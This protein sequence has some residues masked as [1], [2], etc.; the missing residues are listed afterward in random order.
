MRWSAVPNSSEEADWLERHGRFGSKA[1][2]L[3]N[4]K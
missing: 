2:M 3:D 4:R 1:A